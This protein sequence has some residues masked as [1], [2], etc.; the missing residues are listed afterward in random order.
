MEDSRP[1]GLKVEL[2]PCHCVVFSTIGDNFYTHKASL[3]PGL[4]ICNLSWK[5]DKMQEVICD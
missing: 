2:F 4:G 1:E 3:C 5:P